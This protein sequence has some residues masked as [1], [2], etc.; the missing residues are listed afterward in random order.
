[1]STPPMIDKRQL[2]ASVCRDSY[3]DFF[4]E[5]WSVV[6]PERLILS[7]HMAYLARVIQRM[8]ERVFAGKAKKYDLVINLPPG[9]SKSSLVSV[10]L[11]AWCWTRMPTFKFIGASYSYHLAMDLSRKTRQIVDS[12]KYRELFPDI[13]LSE[14][15]NTKAYFQN[16]AGGYRLAVGVNGSVT[17]WHGHMT[18]V[19]DPINPERAAS[20]I[21]LTTAG[22]WIIDTLSTRK[23]DLRVCPDILVQ[24]RL[25]QDDPSAQFLRLKEVKHISLPAEL[26]D[27]VKPVSLRRF[28]KKGLLDHIRLGPKVLERQRQKGDM[29]FAGQYQQRPAPPGGL[30]FKV[31]KLQ[32]GIPPEPQQFRMLV[33]AWDKAG[34]AKKRSSWTVGVLMGVDHHGRY[35]VLDVVRGKWE[36]FRRESIIRDTAVIDTVRVR[37][38]VEREPGSGGLESSQAT[39]RNLAGFRA[40]ED[41]VNAS[42]GGKEYRADVFATQVNGSNVYLPA[43]LRQGESWTGWAKDFVEELLFFPNSRWKD[44]VDASSMAFRFLQKRRVRIGGIL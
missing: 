41:V 35:W 20:E 22:R 36:A 7:W 15:Q 21:E 33:R 6:V 23:V 3:L 24:Q 2:L 13:Q 32:W 19:D 34:T 30:M 44:Q 1:M 42:V 29:F 10:F 16:T 28:Y 5:F 27:D 25:H 4:R 38:V 8:A 12:E 14:E 39:I 11:P 9:M 31:E 37:I 40:E 17:G 43:R 26:S 18:V